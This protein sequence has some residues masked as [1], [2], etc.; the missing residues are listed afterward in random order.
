M[1]N[2]TRLILLLLAPLL[3]SCA[4]MDSSPAYI[5]MCPRLIS[6]PPEVQQQAA[7]ELSAL[8]PD[9]ATLTLMADYANLR[10]QCRAR[11]E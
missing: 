3:M 10:A 11:S 2:P 4:G 1:R 7:S 9:A 8:P 6:Y 5:T